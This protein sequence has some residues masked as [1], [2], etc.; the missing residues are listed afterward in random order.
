MADSFEIDTILST[1]NHQPLETVSMWIYTQEIEP[2]GRSLVNVETGA[3]IYA[4]QMGNIIA[5]HSQYMAGESHTHGHVLGE[6]VTMQEALEAL[7]SL[8]HQLG[9]FD[10]V[11]NIPLNRPAQ[12]ETFRTP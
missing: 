12:R 8:A 7:S 3:R 5:L 11:R 6:F 10:I 1:I 9:A 4:H 2:D